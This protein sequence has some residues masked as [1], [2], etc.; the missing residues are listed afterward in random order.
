MPIPSRSAAGP[1]SVVLCL[2][3]VLGAA[4]LAVPSLKVHASDAP[5]RQQTEEQETILRLEHAWAD[6]D[7][8]HDVRVFEEVLAD[9]FIGQWADGTTTDKKETI[10]SF[11][12]GQDVYEQSTL[13]PLNVRIYGDTAVVNGTFTETSTLSGRDGSGTYNFMDVWV[14][15]NGKWQIVAFQSLR[16]SLAHP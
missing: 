8:K 14:R 13:G 5:L 7:T 1:R 12:S 6:A 11:A 9:D 15:R 2:L 10:A 3:G 16:L 4:L